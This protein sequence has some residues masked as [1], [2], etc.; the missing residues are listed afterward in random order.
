MFHLFCTA[1]HLAGFAE[2]TATENWATGKKATENWATGKYGNGKKGNWTCGGGRVDNWATEIRGCPLKTRRLLVERKEV[3][4][5]RNA[6]TVFYV[7]TNI[8][9]Q[10]G[11]ILA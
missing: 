3:C 5:S 11:D 9:N 7:G 1:V 4:W 10:S 6:R 2:K 8:L